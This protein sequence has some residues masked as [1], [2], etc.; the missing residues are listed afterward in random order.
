MTVF[1]GRD[2]VIQ[3]LLNRFD[4]A[5]GGEGGVLFIS[6]EAGAGKSALV[7]RFLVEAAL[8]VPDA[9]VIAT[10]CSEQ[11]GAGEP[12][13]PFVDAFRDLTAG[14]KRLGR[15][16]SLRE[17]AAQLAPFWVQAIPVAGDI[18]AATVVTAAELKQSFGGTAATVAPPSAEALFFQYTELFLAAATE[19]PL[20]LFIDDLHWA[21][22]ASV[23]LLGHLARKVA[24][25]PALIVGTYRTADVEVA[26]HPVKQAKLELQRYG[27]AEELVLEALDSASLAKLVE[28]ELGAPPTPELLHLLTRRAGGNPLFFGELLKWL[29][30]QEH[31]IRTNGEWSLAGTIEEIQ[32]PRSA[33]SVIE[34]RLARL[35]DE[36]YRVLEYASVEGD[37]FDSTVLA[38]LLGL[39][40][41]ELEERIDPIVRT[42][43]LVRL[44]ETRNLPNGEPTSV[45]Q[46]SHTLIQD[47]LLENLRGK[48]RILLHRK[49]AGILEEIYSDDTDLISHK[50]AIHYDQGRVSEKACDFALRAAERASRVYAHWDAIELLQLA[51]RNS[52]SEGERIEALDRLGDAH[53]FVGHYAQALEH[54]REAL[55]MVGAGG[56][57]RALSIR[58][59]VAMVER[60]LGSRPPEELTAQL[61]SLAQEAREGGASE[62]LCDI[63]WSLCL[64]P[65]SK[66]EVAEE[67]LEVA[68]QLGN[69]ELES[70]AH[71]MLATTLMFG[72]DPA[73]ATEHLAE[74]LQCAESRGDKFRMGRCHNLIAIV[75]V[76]LGD[77]R[78]AV[79]SFEAAASLFDEVKDPRTESSARNNLAQLLI[80]T[81]EWEEADENLRE[82]VRLDQRMGATASLLHPLEN[83]ARMYEGMGDRAQAQVQWRELL[84]L[85]GETGYWDTEIVARCGLGSGHLESGDLESARA[86]LR[87]ARELVRDEAWTEVR[88]DLDLLA[89]RIAA[90]E[91][92]TAGVLKILESAERELASRDRYVWACYRLY[93]GELLSGEDDARALEILE[94]ARDVFRRLGAR[95]MIQRADE[96]IAVSRGGS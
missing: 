30:E 48:R 17:L 15:K 53:R 95:P 42:H 35:D 64:V 12:Y 36:T 83:R 38:Q 74:A 39:D 82:A 21:D 71:Y 93:Q 68:G 66:R 3:D 56:Y 86:E 81:G 59:K 11:Y 69:S 55:S 72:E 58:T 45:Y 94:E 7:T 6:G 2:Q 77:Y 29:L 41:L 27:V 80:R 85:A 8:R 62:E 89:A 90:A 65:G 57:R 25:K 75:H 34:K 16:R 28:Q 33:E 87:A 91:G 19:H 24:D 70:K 23:S 60:D 49:V 63:L 22:R 79:K 84:E 4:R 5:V 43:K 9:W 76:L 50:L 47:V 78:K 1:V 26:K 13:Q 32:V 20:L 67:A 96:L 44:A 73:E 92:D 46:F 51:F 18:I 88:E 54:Y 40:E 31:A 14:G 61:E 52:Q 10:G 37:E